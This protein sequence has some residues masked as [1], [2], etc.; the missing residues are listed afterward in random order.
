VHDTNRTT[1]IR[2]EADNY[3][4]SL[5][6][7]RPVGGAMKIR[8]LPA[9]LIS[10]SSPIRLGFW[11]DRAHQKEALQADI[12]RY[13]HAAP[14]DLGAQP[15]ALASIEFHRVRAKGRFMPEQVVFLD[16]RPYND[17]PGFYVRDAV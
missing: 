17:Q 11:R 8:W 9:L 6:R 12:V 4:T 13:E 15:V 2:Q 14:V 7:L 5:S 16:N 3:R 1:A 10:P